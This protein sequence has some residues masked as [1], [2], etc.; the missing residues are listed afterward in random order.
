MFSINGFFH[1]DKLTIM[2]IA[3]FLYLPPIVWKG[4]SVGHI[5]ENDLFFFVLEGECFLSIDSENYIIKP[6]QLAYLPKG[7]RRAYTHVSKRFSMYEMAFSATCDDEN[8]MQLLGLTE[9]NFV[10]NIAD[11]EKLSTLFESSHR[12]ELYKNP[13]YDIGWC[14]NI[15]NI[16]RM[17]AN[18]RQKQNSQESRFFKTVLDYMSANLSK[19]IK[20]EQLAELVHL[21][22]T[23]FIKR[24]KKNYGIPPIA[25]FNRMKMYKAMGMLSGTDM[26]I[27]QIGK[28]VGITDTSYFARAFKKY[29]NITPS[30]YRIEF[31]KENFPDY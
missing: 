27:E 21:Q 13:L 23:Y 8:L 28:K 2:P 16:I 7:K 30:Q 22:P 4:D 15:I 9:E 14:A 26:P 6:G 12:K 24:F 31:K 1:L 17:Y 19:T 11:T 10:V 18:E 29:C 25:Y 3:T 5:G 20:T